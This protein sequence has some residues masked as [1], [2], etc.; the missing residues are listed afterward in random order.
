MIQ[1]MKTRIFFYVMMLATPPLVAAGS[2]GES[3]LLQKVPIGHTPRFTV[4]STVVI[5]SGSFALKWVFPDGPVS[6]RFELQ[7]DTDKDFSSPQIIYVGPDRGTYI[8]GLLNGDF[9]YRVRALNTQET[10]TSP[11][12]SPIHRTVQHPSLDFVFSLMSVGALV[13]I[14]TISMITKGIQ[15][16]KSLVNASPL[17]NW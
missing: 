9:F 4:P 10:Y 7:Q 16:E 15:K 11:W 5:P 13:F 8:S 1:V 14:S 17:P 2:S 3:P 12:S 6:H